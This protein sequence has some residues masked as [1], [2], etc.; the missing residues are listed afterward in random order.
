MTQSRRELKLKYVVAHTSHG[1]VTR[2]QVFLARKSGEWTLDLDA[3]QLFDS[4]SDAAISLALMK[5]NKEIPDIV[6]LDRINIH[7]CTYADRNLGSIV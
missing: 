6:D 7:V 3:A 5:G 1:G 4:A 2:E